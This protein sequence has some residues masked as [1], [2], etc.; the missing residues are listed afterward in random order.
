MSACPGQQGVD[1]DS[2]QV[3]DGDLRRS[4]GWLSSVGLEV[5]QQRPPPTGTAGAAYRR[6]PASSRKMS[7][8]LSA[9][10]T[11]ESFS[12]IFF[13]LPLFRYC[14]STNSNQADDKKKRWK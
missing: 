6:D 9:E 10:T 4:H 11:K 3:L 2:G 1:R 8:L 5:L 12:Y 13:L 14:I 7:A